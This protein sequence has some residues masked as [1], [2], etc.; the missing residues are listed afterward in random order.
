MTTHMGPHAARKLVRIHTDVQHRLKQC[1]WIDNNFKK[2]INITARRGLICYPGDV[3][4]Q[5]SYD[6]AKFDHILWVV[7]G[8]GKVKTLAHTC[9]PLYIPVYQVLT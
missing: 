7:G 2:I 9:I 1:M 8:G 6:V 4:K 3:G 5:F